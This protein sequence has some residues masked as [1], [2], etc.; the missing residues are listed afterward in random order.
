M[1]WSRTHVEGM[2]DAMFNM[3]ISPCSTR[4]IN[5]FALMLVRNLMFEWKD[6]ISGKKP[7]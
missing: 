2:C 3:P 1:A 4:K 7:N 5:S 6:K